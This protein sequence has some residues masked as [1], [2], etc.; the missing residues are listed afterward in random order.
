MKASS[1]LPLPAEN[2]MELSRP[3]G[4]ASRTR[5]TTS[6][7]CFPSTSS[8]IGGAREGKGV[9]RTPARK[10]TLVGG[11]I[12]LCPPRPASHCRLLS[13]C[14]S[15]YP[16]IYP[17]TIHL[18]ILLPSHPSLSPGIYPSNH[19]SFPPSFHSSFYLHLS[20]IYSLYL[21]SICPSIHPSSQ[22]PI[23]HI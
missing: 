1:S 10:H 2:Q 7:C 16:S 15:F 20:Y 19:S 23:Y 13:L 5:Q 22:T 12:C 17:S 14:L 9:P 3:G 18:F 11:Y 6:V 4:A 8:V 21:P